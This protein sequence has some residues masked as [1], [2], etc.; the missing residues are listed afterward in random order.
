MDSQPESVG[1]N[2]YICTIIGAEAPPKFGTKKTR[3]EIQCFK[4]GAV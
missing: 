3:Y 2:D 4:Q 1:K